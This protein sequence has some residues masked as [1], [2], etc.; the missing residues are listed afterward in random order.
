ML[1]SARKYGY[2]SYELQARLALGEIELLSGSPAAK[3]R[4][5]S[6]ENKARGKG[7]LLIA[8]EAAA[9]AKTS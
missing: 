7:M 6:L 3:T 9:L 8:I 4:L 1:A 2:L 5:R